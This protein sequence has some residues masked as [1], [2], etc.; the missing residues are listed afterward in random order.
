MEKNITQ[1]DPPE[2]TV[3]VVDAEQG[4]EGQTRE[5][6]TTAQ[7]VVWTPRFIVL[8]G[9]MIAIGLSAESLLTQGWLNGIYREEWVL[10]A[11]TLLVLGCLVVLVRKGK[12]TWIRVGAVAGCV[13]AVFTSA[14]YTALLLGIG[15]NSVI[16]AQFHA[17]MACAL[18]ATT[19]CLSTHRIPFRH[20]D[21]LV[22][23]LTPLVGGI[24][25][26]TLYTLAR[27]DPHHTRVLANDTTMVL[28]AL[29][30]TLWWLR[31][32]C[33]RSKPIV[34][35]LFGL[36]PFLFLL[37][38]LVPIDTIGTPFFLSQLL[39][40]CLFLGVLRVVQGETHHHK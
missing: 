9:L 33:W 15:K 6:P 40:L 20:W 7:T 4:Q 28:L 23:W 29:C 2:K 14:S 17:T 13:W 1:T 12:A 18:L 24:A 38:P 31:P 30:V 36:V 39:L 19:I 32:S 3:T 27:T 21:S 34:T 16:L 22:F 35:F 37:T 26:L 10:L 11:H 25:V 8:F 5:T